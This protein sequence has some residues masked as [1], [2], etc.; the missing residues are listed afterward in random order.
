MSE[1]S[2]EEFKEQLDGVSA[3]VDGVA[4]EYIDLSLD[5]RQKSKDYIEKT[6]KSLQKVQKGLEEADPDSRVVQVVGLQSRNATVEDFEESFKYCDQERLHSK[7]R[8]EYVSW[9]PDVKSFKR[10]I[11]YHLDA[12]HMLLPA[13]T[14]WFLEFHKASDAK[15]ALTLPSFNI[16]VKET[17]CVGC[18]G[19]NFI[20][21]SQDPAL[22]ATF[23]KIGGLVERLKAIDKEY[24]EIG[25]DRRRGSMMPELSEIFF[26]EQYILAELPK[27]KKL[28]AEGKSLDHN[29]MGLLSKIPAKTNII[30]ARIKLLYDEE[31]DIK[32]E[33]CEFRLNGFKFFFEV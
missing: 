1:K 20:K 16:R 14:E 13:A 30:H 32:I 3:R 23:R 18:F 19:V 21:P 24:K 9:V 33:I 4:A 17:N 26:D 2:V 27:I 15:H 22:S 7:R 8:N 11:N 25:A 31:S 29:A 10:E 28:R 12:N 5:S 6:I